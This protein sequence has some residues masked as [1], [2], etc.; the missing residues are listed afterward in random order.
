MFN[1]IRNFF[2]KIQPIIDFIRGKDRNTSDQDSFPEGVIFLHPDVSNWEQAATLHSVNIDNRTISM[3][4]THSRIW[5][6]YDFDNMTL[7]ANP[8][9]I[10]KRNGKWY[11]ATWEWLRFGQEA[12]ASSAVEGGHIKRREFDGWRPQSGEKLG[13]FV[14]GLVRGRERN[15]SERTNIVWVNWP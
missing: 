12:K 8:W 11:A 6:G 14:S 3:P 5:P 9:V 4:Y 1:S 2:R 10:A 15:V 7:N 13:F